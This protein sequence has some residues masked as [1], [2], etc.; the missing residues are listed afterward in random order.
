MPYAWGVSIWF[1]GVFVGGLLKLLGTCFWIVRGPVIFGFITSGSWGCE[2]LIFCLPML[3][4]YFRDIV[5]P[6]EII[7]GSF[8]HTSFCGKFGRPEML[9]GLIRSLSPLMQLSFR[10]TLTVGAFWHPDLRAI[11]FGRRSADNSPR[12]PWGPS[13]SLI[14]F[15]VPRTNFARAPHQGYAHPSR[16]PWDLFGT[17]TSGHYFWVRLCPRLLAGTPRPLAKPH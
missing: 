11:I 15:R 16:G 10:S 12:A 2:S 13:R 1:L 7:F 5:H 4:F 6:L 9:S 3:Y 8:C 14:P 17:L